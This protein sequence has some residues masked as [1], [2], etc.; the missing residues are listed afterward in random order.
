[1]PTGKLAMHYAL[2][3]H[4][5]QLQYNWIILKPKIVQ[6]SKYKTQAMT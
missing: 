4:I 2:K 3:N 6:K 1:M 5:L